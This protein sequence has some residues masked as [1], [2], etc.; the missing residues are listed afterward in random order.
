MLKNLS[1][2]TL[3]G[4]ALCLLFSCSSKKNAATSETAATNGAEAAGAGGRIKLITLDPGHFHAALVQKPMY[5]QVDPVVHVYAP[6]GEDVQEHLK[7][8]EA[9]NTRPEIPTKWKEEVYTGTDYLQKMVAEKKG[10]VVVMAGN[11][12]RK[13]E[14]INTAINAGFNVLADKPMAINTQDFAHLKEAFATAEKKNLLLYDIMTERS[15]ITTMLQREFSRLPEV[16]GQLQKGTPT[17]PAITKE[18]VH[19]FFKYVSGAPIKRP[20]WFFDVTQQGEGI[21]D[22]TTHLVD[23]VQWECYP[24]QKIDY[25][26]DIAINSARH[27]KTTLSPSQF[28][29]VTALTSYPDFLKKGV[30]KDSLLGVYANGEINYQLK[31]THAKVSVIWN[32]QAPEG[33]GD[34]HFSIMK[35]TKANLVIRQG[36]EQNYKPELYIEPVKGTDLKAFETSLKGAL[37]KVQ[38]NYPGIEVKQIASGWQVQIPEKYH[39]GHEAHFGQVMER[40]LQY[41]GAGK[42][43]EWEVPNML[44][45]YYTTTKALELARGAK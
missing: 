37:A 36:K 28:K 35:G 19:H 4:L 2:V 25:E 16:F 39:N 20:A 12:A 13:T 32:F 22:V 29:K 31:G 3:P 5:D 23:L 17:E 10:N 34:T 11:N 38:G 42:L 41:L 43:P 44:A 1:S 21:V 24:D 33:A 15:E 6:A 40:Y 26:K 18:S 9:Y 30:E 45:K 7:K 14:Y 27:W 8:I